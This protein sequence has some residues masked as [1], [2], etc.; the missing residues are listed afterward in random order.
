LKSNLKL[1]ELTKKLNDLAETRNFES[2][3]KSHWDQLVKSKEIEDLKA[4]LNHVV[5]EKL[6]ADTSNISGHVLKTIKIP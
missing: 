3:S 4:S 6:G 1:I 2:F 5:K